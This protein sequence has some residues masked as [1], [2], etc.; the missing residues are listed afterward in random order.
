MCSAPWR[1]S[2]TDSPISSVSETRSRTSLADMRASRCIRPPV[3]VVPFGSEV[4]VVERLLGA[5]VDRSPLTDAFPN[6]LHLAICDEVFPV[7]LHAVML[8][9][10]AVEKGELPYHH[11]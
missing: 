1:R 3:G 5:Q 10:L 7:K 6:K 2:W 11:R 9:D 8:R 4:V